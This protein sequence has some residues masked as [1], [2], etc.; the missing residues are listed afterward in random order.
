MREKRILEIYWP[1][2]VVH[3]LTRVAA[4]VLP[5]RARD[6]LRA[7]GEVFDLPRLLLLVRAATRAGIPHV[8]LV[9]LA[10]FVVFLI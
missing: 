9:L 5:K 1:S 3:I 8:L 4:H 7:V 6:E 2:F 10:L